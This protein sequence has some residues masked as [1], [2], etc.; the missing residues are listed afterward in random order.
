MDKQHL[1]EIVWSLELRELQVN[2][3]DEHELPLF[4]D[5]LEEAINDVLTNYEVEEIE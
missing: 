4:Y 3:L 2:H 1:G 5:S